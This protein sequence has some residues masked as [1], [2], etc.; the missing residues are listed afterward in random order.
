MPG[1]GRGADSRA[2]P[3]PTYPIESVDNALK[4]LHLFRKQRVVRVS[5]ASE[6]LG[7]ARSTAHRLL[8]ML[9]YH[10]FVRQDPVT[11]AYLA[12]RGLVDLGL[13]AVRSLEARRL[14]RPALERLCRELDETVHLAV[15][16]GRSVL[17]IDSVESSRTLRVGA[18]TGIL[19]PAHATAAGKALL[20]ELSTEE[21]HT[22][23]GDVR[24]EALTPRTLTRLADLER[25]LEHVRERGYATS[26]EEAEPGVSAVAAAVRGLGALP[27]PA[28]TV[29]AP[30]SRVGRT[31]VERIAAALL[32]ATGSLAR[33]PAR[34]GGTEPPGRADP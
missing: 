14:A 10:G 12:G 4:L 6:L 3:R 22:L 18:R 28:I 34:P 9:Q 19:L 15:L 7:I 20:A 21:V 25:E 1:D 32:A 31:D 27:Q 11:K 16:D 8:A 26:S 33:P 2:A 13:A 23:L 29:G 30:S 24:L 17:Y 5:E